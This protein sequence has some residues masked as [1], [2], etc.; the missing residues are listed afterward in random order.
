M[1]KRHSYD[2]RE[3]N[4]D[5]CS[6]PKQQRHDDHDKMPDLNNIFNGEVC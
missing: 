6:F 2:D 4:Y 1:L 3:G 5:A